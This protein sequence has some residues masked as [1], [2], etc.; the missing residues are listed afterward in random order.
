MKQKVCS[1]TQGPDLCSEK[2]QG[3]GGRWQVGR[4]WCLK[5]TPPLSFPA[6]HHACLLLSQAWGLVMLRS[7]GVRSEM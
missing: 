7:S 2:L 6:P 5:E 3:L 4:S 1:I